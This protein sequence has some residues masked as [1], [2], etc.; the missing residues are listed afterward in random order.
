MDTT[1][2]LHFLS[3]NYGG[4]NEDNCD[5]PQKISCTYCYN[6]CPQPC[7]RPPL[8][9]TR[10]SWTPTGKSRTVSCGVTIPF[11]WVLVHK[12]LLCSPE[13]YFPVLCKFWQLYGGVNG[14][15]LQEDLCHTHTQSPCPCGRPLPTHNST[16]DAQTQ[17]CLSLCG[18]PGS[19]CTQGLSEPSEHL[20]WVR[21]LILNVN[22][23]LLRSCWDFSFAHRCGVSP[24]SCSSAYRLTG[25]SLTLDVGYLHRWLDGITDSTDMSLSKHWEWVMD[26]EAWHAAL[27][28]VTKSRTRLSD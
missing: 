4:G 11:S 26:R 5:L 3:L 7:S 10:D 27:H 28:G 18:V 21:G 24:H 9:F 12:I 22:S 2:R 6:P 17:F 14:N 20:W 1:E 23:P 13:I 15:L 25:I 8:T 16:G 19:W